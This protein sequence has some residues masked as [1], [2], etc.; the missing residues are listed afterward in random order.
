MYAVGIIAEQDVQSEMHFL[1]R[2]TTRTAVLHFSRY[3]SKLRQAVAL[4][5]FLGLSWWDIVVLRIAED[6]AGGI[7]GIA[8]GIAV[9]DRQSP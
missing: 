4:V 8:V 9:V 2:T 6:I 7:A 3:Y 1:L 5:P